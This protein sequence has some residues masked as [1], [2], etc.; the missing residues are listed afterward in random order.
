MIAKHLAL[1]S[2]FVLTDTFRQLQAEQ[3][4]LWQ[5]C[6]VTSTQIVFVCAC[7][8]VNEGAAE[9]PTQSYHYLGD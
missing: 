4:E 2:K 3:K 9:G 1:T 7:V 5:L 8:C 6:T